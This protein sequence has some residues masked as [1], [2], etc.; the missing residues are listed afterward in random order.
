VSSRPSWLPQSNPD[1]RMKST[2]STVETG[3]AGWL[4]VVVGYC[5]EYRQSVGHICSTRLRR[6]SEDFGNLSFDWLFSYP[7]YYFRL[8]S[9]DRH[10]SPTVKRTSGV[11]R[12]SVPTLLAAYIYPVSQLI[13]SHGDGRYQYIRMT[14]SYS[15]PCV[16]QICVLIRFTKKN[17]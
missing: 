6:L 13:T 2:D 15:W 17:T 11:P 1:G 16:R 12:R 5:P 3:D 4:I 7:S 10:C 14:I 8:E 9:L